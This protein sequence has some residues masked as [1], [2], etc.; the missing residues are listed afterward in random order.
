VIHVKSQDS[1]LARLPIFAPQPFQQLMQEKTA[2]APGALAPGVR[3]CATDP[4]KPF[5]RLLLACAPPHSISNGLVF[6]TSRM[7]G[8]LRPETFDRT[9]R[10]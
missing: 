9:C 10:Q 5:P 3:V 2:H 4:A 1:C 8:I 7:D 6:Q